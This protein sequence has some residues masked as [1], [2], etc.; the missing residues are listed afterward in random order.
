MTL[1]SPSLDAA[2]AGAP[3]YRALRAPLHDPLHAPLHQPLHERLSV[4]VLTYRRPD[5]LG[6]TLHALHAL[7]DVPR[8]VVVNNDAHDA[9]VARVVAR[10]PGV[11]LV[12]CPRNL[13]AA[14]RNEGVQLVR[15]PYVAFC[16]D[17]TWWAPGSLERA[18][19]ALA[20]HPRLAAVAARVLVEPGGREDPTCHVMATSPLDAQ[21]LPGPALIG[22][23]GG[24]VVMRT[25]AYRA[26]GGYA[27]RLFIGCEE[28]LMGLDLLAAGWRMVYL[29]DVMAHHQPS[30]LRDAVERRWLHARN[31]LWIAWLRLPADST[32]HETR[33]VLRE[34]RRE[35]LAWPVLWRTALGLPWVWRHRR[36][37]PP[38]VEA[39]RRQVL[40]APRPWRARAAVAS[41]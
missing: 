27:E 37:V 1:P 40:G 15:T 36:P 8:I 31:T 7:P 3:A 20:A 34:A 18:A 10:Y 28:R 23:M 38:Q 24:A 39:L 11:Q 17:D 33:R 5:S 32:W 16:D 30:P 4:V 12:H 9:R 26:V 21:G 25:Q 13:G 2:P 6:R 22:F 35:G 41:A 29:H 19:D 14:G